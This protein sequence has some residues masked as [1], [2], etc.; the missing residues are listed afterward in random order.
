LGPITVAAWAGAPKSAA[1]AN[2]ALIAKR[3]MLSG[4]QEE[5]GSV[6]HNRGVL[7]ALPRLA[8]HFKVLGVNYAEPWQ[9]IL[10]APN[11]AGQ[12]GSQRTLRESDVGNVASL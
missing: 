9:L 11:P 3:D 8:S 5:K 1:V 4:I 12:N 2:K 7:G 10:F 6:L